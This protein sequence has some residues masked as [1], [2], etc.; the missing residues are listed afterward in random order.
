MFRCLSCGFRAGTE[1]SEGTGIRCA[2][3]GRYVQWN[4]S[5][6]TF[7]HL[8]KGISRHHCQFCSVSQTLHGRALI[9]TR[10]H[11]L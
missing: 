9:G 4:F 3:W 8:G 5:L 7:Y 1:E 11:A 2:L 6:N 10:G